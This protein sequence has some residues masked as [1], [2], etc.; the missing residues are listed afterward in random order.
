M[1]VLDLLDVLD[2]LAEDQREFALSALLNELT[3]YSHYVILESQLNWDGDSS[4]KDFIIYQNEVIR[5]CVKIEMSFYGSV[6]RTYLG[7]EPLSLR[8]ELRLR[9]DK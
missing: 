7:L 9:N 4:Y 3:I 2:F 5:E 1:I 8:T 6:V